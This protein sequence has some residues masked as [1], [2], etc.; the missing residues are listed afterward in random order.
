MLNNQGSGTRSVKQ[1]LAAMLAASVLAGCATTTAPDY[2]PRLAGGTVGYNDW[3]LSP[4]RYRVSFSGSTAN[5]RDDVERYL[6]R[7]AAEVTLASGY[8]HFVLSNRDTEREPN[9]YAN[10]YLYSPYSHYYPYRSWY[11]NHPYWYG[12]WQSITYSAYSDIMM[13][14][15]EEARRFPNAI[16]AL[17]LLQ[18]LTPPVPVASAM[19]P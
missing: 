3:Q 4:N 2:R 14:M 12:G 8:T 17:P 11:W 1:A 16:E 5:T 6:L 19:P 13:F 9:F 10:N 7:R 15:P 18:R